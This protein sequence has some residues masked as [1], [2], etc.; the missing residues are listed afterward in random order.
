MLY[1]ECCNLHLVNIMC[2]AYILSILL[3]VSLCNNNFLKKNIFFLQLCCR[4]CTLSILFDVV[5]LEYSMQCFMLNVLK[6]Y[7]VDI[8]CGIY[9]SLILDVVS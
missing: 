8:M 9:L 5:Y 4:V 6:C 1:V 3:D 2:E 7:V